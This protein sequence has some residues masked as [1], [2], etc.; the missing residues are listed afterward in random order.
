[1]VDE[2]RAVVRIRTRQGERQLPPDALQR[3]KTHT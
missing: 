3:F 2:F 1:M